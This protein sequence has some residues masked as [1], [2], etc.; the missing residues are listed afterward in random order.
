[1]QKNILIIAALLCPFLAQAQTL[2]IGNNA[3]LYVSA[4]DINNPHISIKGA[5]KNNG[6]LT[7]NT[8]HIVSSASVQNNGTIKGKGLIAATSGIN[9]SSVANLSPGIAGIGTMIV[10]GN[11]TLNNSVL[12]IGL[13]GTT[14]GT[15]HDEVQVVGTSNL[16]GGT[17]NVSFTSGYT[18]VGGE[19]FVII[20]S[21]NLNG[22]F[23]T[24]NLPAL[25][26]SLTWQTDYD[27][28]AGTVSL[29]IISGSLPV[30][31]LHFNANKNADKIDL[32]WA[33][34]A[35]INTRDFEIERSTDGH[36]F[37]KIGSVLAKGSN[38]NYSF[39]DTKLTNNTYYYRLKIND[40]DGYIEYSNVVA[41]RFDSKA[42]TKIFPNPTN[43]FINI[44]A[45]ETDLPTQ[46]FDVKGVLLQDFSTTPNQID[47]TELPSGFYFLKIGEQVTKIIKN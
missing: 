10:I 20:R 15:T 37:T 34:A 36:I 8:G 6:A 16:S 19:S 1:M 29:R 26:G 31:L 3:T 28:A 33:T 25:S 4:P 30:E 24:I 39:I 21:I 44:S 32:F 17:L 14:A 2:Y 12:I 47:L 42:E 46:V 40:F 43:G 41:V 5:V 13:G 18:P 23:A 38:S 9:S 11:Y 35:E 22:T 7:L 27:T 45:I